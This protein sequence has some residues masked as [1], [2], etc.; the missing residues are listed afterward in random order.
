MKKEEE[1]KKQKR[2][3]GEDEGKGL[4]SQQFGHWPN[5]RKKKEKRKKR[6]NQIIY[7]AKWTNQIVY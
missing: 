4:T 6:A 5:Q 2:K 7:W 3:K 1:K